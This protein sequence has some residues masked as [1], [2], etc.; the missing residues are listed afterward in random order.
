MIVVNSHRFDIKTKFFRS[1]RKL[2]YFAMSTA[3][4]T[5]RFYDNEKVA[6]TTRPCYQELVFQIYAKLF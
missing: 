3:L 1:I 2:L 5:L 6:D 4:A